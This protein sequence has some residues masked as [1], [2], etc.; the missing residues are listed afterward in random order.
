M[1]DEEKK[2]IADYINTHRMYPDNYK[3]SRDLKILCQLNRGYRYD[4]ET[5]T[6]TRLEGRINDNGDFEIVGSFTFPLGKP[7]EKVPS[8]S[9]NLDYIKRSFNELLYEWGYTRDVT[10][11]TIRD[12]VS[13]AEYIRSTYYQ[14]GHVNNDMRYTDIEEWTRRTQRIRYYIRT[15]KPYI[16]SVTCC[17]KH[18]SKYDD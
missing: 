6:I 12:I 9:Y 5:N 15:Y 3:G 17:Q 4:D 1:S 14:K 10:N 7:E 11:W 16:E 18:N 13:E 8:V 2:Q